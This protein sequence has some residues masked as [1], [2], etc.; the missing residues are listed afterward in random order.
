MGIHLVDNRDSIKG[1]LN[2]CVTIEQSAVILESMLGQIAQP[3]L[4]GSVENP[5][6]IIR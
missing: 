2:R 1:Q 6:A 5:A 3:L 4:S